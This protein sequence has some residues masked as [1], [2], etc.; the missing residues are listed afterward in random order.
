[1]KRTHLSILRPFMYMVGLL[2]MLATCTPNLTVPNANT[3]TNAGAR[4]LYRCGTTTPFTS[5]T[6][7]C[8]D[9]SALWSTDFETT[10]SDP[11]LF[12]SHLTNQAYNLDSIRISTDQARAG[13]KSL[14]FTWGQN[15]YTG[16]GTAN[17]NNSTHSEVYVKCPNQGT[18]QEK[19]IGFSMYL[20]AAKMQSDGTVNLFQWHGYYPYASAPNQGC[21]QQ[22]PVAFDLRSDNKIYVSTRTI[23]SIACKCP[24]P[25]NDATN[26]TYYSFPLASFD[27]W[28]DI[29]IHIRFD[30]AADNAQTGLLE[31]WQNGNR[32][33]NASN[34]DIGYPDGDEYI[35]FGLYCWPR[36]FGQIYTKPNK[37]IYFD[38][39]KDANQT[40]SYA[41]VAPSSPSNPMKPQVN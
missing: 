25:I 22:A 32:V 11:H 29:V 8:Y 39:F 37:L 26:S 13:S 5:T 18:R 20:P 28:V 23:D 3:P 12:D 40:G 9:N 1:M 14:K 30:D 41:T 35:K 7:A 15:Q 38:S 24:T 10:Y 17:A 21:Y 6:Y 27:Q 4:V 16:D 19:W 31:I 2:I 34:V 36:A 33:V